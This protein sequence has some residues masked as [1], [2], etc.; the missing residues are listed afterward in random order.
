[1]AARASTI[2]SDSW[3]EDEDLQKDLEQYIGQ[4]LHRQEVLDFMMR[5]YQE[6]AWSLRTLDRR[7]SHF[8]IRRHDKGVSVDDLRVAVQRELDGPG[9]LLGYR[10]LHGKIR[11]VH[12]LNV[13]RDAVYDMM[14]DLDPDGLKNRVLTNKRRKRVNGAFVTR[15]PNWVHS[16][17]G[18]AKLMGYQKSTFPLA[19]YGCPDSASRKLLWLKIWTTNSDPRIVGRWYFEYL[20]ETRMIGQHLRIDKGTE[21]GDMATIHAFLMSEL[22]IEDPVATVIYGPLTSNQVW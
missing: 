18:H 19:I 10:A 1:M 5:D 17:D 9:K 13:P 12:K 6:Y 22:G 4:G 14:Y 11:K 16:L 7:C 21:T 8:G 2:R 20:F 15:G 3:K